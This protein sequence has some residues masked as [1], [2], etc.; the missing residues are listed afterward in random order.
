[1]KTSKFQ[2]SA[3][4]VSEKHKKKLLILSTESSLQVVLYSQFTAGQKNKTRKE[5]VN[6][7]GK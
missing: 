3:K 4:F 7:I 5:L 6:A 2:F 1:M